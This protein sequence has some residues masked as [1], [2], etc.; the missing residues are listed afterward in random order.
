[1]RLRD[2]ATI[3][4]A[5]TPNLIEREA[6]SRRID[7]GA[8]VSGRDLSAVVDDIKERLADVGFADGY[9]AEVLGEATELGAAQSKP[10]AV[11]R[12]PP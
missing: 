6:A 9:H 10:A 4:I 2:V 11:R 12:S 8:N 1:M 5:P 3:T 7:V